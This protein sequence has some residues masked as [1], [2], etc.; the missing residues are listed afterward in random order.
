MRKKFKKLFNVDLEDYIVHLGG[1]NI[2]DFDKF[3][4]DFGIIQELENELEKMRLLKQIIN[5]EMM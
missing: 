3:E 4:N 1:K 5:K 2:L